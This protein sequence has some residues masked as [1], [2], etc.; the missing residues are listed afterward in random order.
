MK[1]NRWEPGEPVNLSDLL[2]I[3]PVASE[4]MRLCDEMDMSFS[5]IMWIV[6]EIMD[7]REALE[8]IESVYYTDD[9]EDDDEF[10]DL[11]WDED[12]ESYEDDELNGAYCTV[13]IRVCTRGQFPEMGF[14]AGIRSREDLKPF[15]D[16]VMDM[17]DKFGS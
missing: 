13:E 10:Y 11:G 2:K 15:L 14:K 5:D 3:T 16:M 7:E 6:S 8:G 4:I 17:V 1:E 12:E 9:E